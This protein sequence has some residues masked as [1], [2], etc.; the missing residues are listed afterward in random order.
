MKIIN[1]S[2]IVEM[3]DTCIPSKSQRREIIT[4]A[5]DRMSVG[6]AYDLLKEVELEY[7]P[8]GDEI[9]FN[10]EFSFKRAIRDGAYSIMINGLDMTGSPGHEEHMLLNLM[11]VAEPYLPKE[12]VDK[13]VAFAENGHYLR[14]ATPDRK[15]G[16]GIFIDESGEM[17]SE[18]SGGL[19][20][21]LEPN[22]HIVEGQVISI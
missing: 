20:R 12:F 4:V 2:F 18:A 21:V 13:M 10:R 1:G 8:E 19:K 15:I 3:E 9:I 5:G 11:K 16:I 22:V 14:Y 7:Y 6:T 17:V